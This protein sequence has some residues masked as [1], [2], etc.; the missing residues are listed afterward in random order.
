MTLPGM[1]KKIRSQCSAGVY[2]LG[3]FCLAL[4]GSLAGSALAMQA[5]GPVSANVRVHVATKSTHPAR[6][7]SAIV[8][9]QR[10]NTP[11]KKPEKPPNPSDASAQPATVTLK[12]GELTVKANNSDLAQIL[13]NVSDL[14]G[15][16]IDGLHTSDRIFGVYGPGNPSDVLTAL[17]SGS[18]YNFIIVGDRSDGAPR[19]LLLT[20]K[21]DKAPTAAE[22]P[23]SSPPAEAPPPVVPDTQ[24]SQ[25]RDARMTQMMRRLETQ[26][27]QQQENA[28]PQ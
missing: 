12:N 10:S 20:A 23:P 9:K 21:T 8:R 4:A 19:K 15:M 11:E 27:K 13:R 22:A 1:A 28:A 14:S 17:L 18:G 16:T 2:A 6:G 24:D 5:S 3:I 26:H 7:R 25:S